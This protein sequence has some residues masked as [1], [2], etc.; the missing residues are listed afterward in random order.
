V[1]TSRPGWQPLD[2]GGFVPAPAVDAAT[3]RKYESAAPRALQV[4]VLAQFGFVNLAA[5]AF[6]Y[7]SDRLAA[8]DKVAAALALVLTLASLGG[9]L[10]R[11]TWAFRLEAA[12]LVAGGAAAVVVA[13]PVFGVAAAAAAAFSLA[14]LVHYRRSLPA[15][16]GLAQSA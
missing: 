16:P 11:K 3:Y 8:S 4:Y 2:Q 7:W 15:G 14:W 9:L 1:F 5:L 6:F 12:R 13:A 10:D